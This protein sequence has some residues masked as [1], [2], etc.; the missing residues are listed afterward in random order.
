MVK[1]KIPNG[2]NLKSL[3]HEKLLPDEKVKIAFSLNYPAAKDI[4]WSF[5]NNCFEASFIW[6]GI[7][8]VAS[9]DE[10]GGLQEEKMS[11]D[12]KQLPVSV[13][14]IVR[15]KF[16]MLYLI[17]AHEINKSGKIVFEII[18][19]SEDKSRYLLLFDEYGS[20][21]KEQL[22]VAVKKFDN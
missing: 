15:K 14:K 12:E 10:K 18:F 1:L 22:L 3:I 7:F 16:R 6:K 19:D 21:L 2:F 9:F 4:E 17:S 8:T 13:L 5:R 11:R 20:L